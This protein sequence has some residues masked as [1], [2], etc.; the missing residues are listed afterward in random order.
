ML[1]LTAEQQQVM[2]RV[3]AELVRQ[4]RELQRTEQ[5]LGDLTLVLGGPGATSYIDGGRVVV[6]RAAVDA[7]DEGE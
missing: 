4:R 1:E 7:I 2:D 3:A 6:E 5:H